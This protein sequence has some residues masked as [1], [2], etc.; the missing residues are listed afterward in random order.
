MAVVIHAYKAQHP[1]F[2]PHDPKA[3]VV[4]KAVIEAIVS[5]VSRLRVAHVGSTSVS[6]CGGKGCIDLLV[7]YPDG[8]LETARRVIA[9]LGFQKQQT[10]DP[11]P[12]DRPMRVGCVE[13]E[14]QAFSVHMHIVAANSPE[15]NELVRFRDALRSNTIIRQDYE[16]VKRRILDGPVLDGVDYAERKGSFIRR[17]LAEQ[18][19]SSQID[20]DV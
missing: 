5:R 2:R 8:L 18:A 10:R 4:A 17:V 1:E 6:G 14:G 20:S 9:E 13:H 11:F 3:R 12:E 19:S 15:V 7:T 16:A